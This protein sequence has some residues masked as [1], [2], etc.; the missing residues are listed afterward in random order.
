MHHLMQDAGYSATATTVVLSAASMFI[1]LCAALAM[2]AHIAPP[3]FLA[4]FLGLTVGY[5]LFT[6]R[7]DRAVA[8]L[9]RPRT[10]AALGKASSPGARQSRPAVE[11]PLRLEPAPVPE[12]ANRPVSKVALQSGPGVPARPENAV[13][14]K[15]ILDGT[16]RR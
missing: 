6:G 8:W 7:R 11:A 2:R 16:N 3:W 15:S 5:Y 4:T 14:A 12:V 13:K 9:R 1:G 10:L